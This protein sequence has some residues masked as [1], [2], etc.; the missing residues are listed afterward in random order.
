LTAK[1][2]SVQFKVT[3]NIQK[4]LVFAVAQHV[5]FRIKFAESFLKLSNLHLSSSFHSG[6]SSYRL[7]RAF[8]GGEPNAAR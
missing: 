5:Q 1:V 7:T 3:G 6:V 4:L 2:I 8:T